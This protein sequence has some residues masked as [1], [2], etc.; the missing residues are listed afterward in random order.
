MNTCNVGDIELQRH[1]PGLKQMPTHQPEREDITTKWSTAFHRS[2]LV[3]RERDSTDTQQ[4]TQI[5]ES[6]DRLVIGTDEIG[7]SDR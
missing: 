6:T 4:G 3:F 1:W 5:A 2:V 7:K